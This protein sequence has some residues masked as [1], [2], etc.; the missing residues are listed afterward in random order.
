MKFASTSFETNCLHFAS[1]YAD[2][3]DEAREDDYGYLA[4]LDAGGYL[5]ILD[6]V[7]GSE[8]SRFDLSLDHVTDLRFGTHSFTS[9]DGQ[10]SHVSGLILTTVNGGVSFVGGAATEQHFNAD[11]ENIKAVVSPPKAT[12]KSLDIVGV[13][14]SVSEPHYEHEKEL[15]HFRMKKV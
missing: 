11:A 3:D 12:A 5:S 15:K 10:L 9:R 7:S 14:L 13:S 4:A 2:N 6:I 8:L 1:I